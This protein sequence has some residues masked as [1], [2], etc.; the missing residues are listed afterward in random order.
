MHL[1]AAQTLATQVSIIHRQVPWAVILPERNAVLRFLHWCSGSGLGRLD[2]GT[3]LLS[4]FIAMLFDDDLG[5]KHSGKV[6]VVIS[7]FRAINQSALLVLKST[8]MA[9]K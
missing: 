1:I 4:G 9:I 8:L 7:A 5:I 2:A 6:T 3:R